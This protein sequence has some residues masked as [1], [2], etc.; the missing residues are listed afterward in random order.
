MSHQERALDLPKEGSGRRPANDRVAQYIRGWGVLGVRALDFTLRRCLGVHEFSN[1][2]DC[3]LRVSTSR[4]RSEFQLAD[5]TGLKRGDLLLELHFWN[6]HLA[7]C[8]GN[9][10]EFRWALCIEKRIRLSLMLLA[11]HTA[12]L[13]AVDDYKAV[14]ARLTISL[15]GAD[16]VIRRLGFTTNYPVRSTSQMTHDRL[17]ILLIW[18]LTWAFHPHGVREGKRAPARADLWMSM[19]EFQRLYGRR[20]YGGR[21]T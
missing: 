20:T 9:G 5:G 3:I 18:L 21:E 19:S 13:Q 7:G 8:G 11:D 16:R 1:R 2:A 12:K 14:H 17:K 10:E 15:E 4:C 6:E